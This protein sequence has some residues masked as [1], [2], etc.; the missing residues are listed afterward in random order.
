MTLPTRLVVIGASS[1]GID[2]LRSLV[3]GLP[4]DFPAPICVVVHTSPDGPRVLSD[5][6]QRAG[7]LP[8]EIAHSG[9]RLNLGRI[10][11]APADCHLLVEPGTLRVSRGPKE[12][13]FRPAIDPL[14][15]SAAQVY[16]PGAIGVILT[17]NLDDGVAGLWTIKRLGGVAIAQDPEEA[18]FPSMPRNAVE[19]VDVDHVV[20]LSQI[21]PLLVTLTKDARM[22]DDVE[23]PSSLDIEINIAREQN[24]IEAGVERL[25]TPSSWACPDC[26]GVLL[27]IDEGGRIRFRCH[28]GHAYSIESLVASVDDQIEADMWTAV[29]ALEEGAL[30]L[31]R[32]AEHIGA[33]HD[34]EH[35]RT[36]IGR[37]EEGHRQ[38]EAIRALL[39]ERNRLPLESER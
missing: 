9:A 25:G 7:H 23:P 36:L 12:N 29:R 8:A 27:K 13:R 3:G 18:A 39:K 20:Q 11:V 38:A 34:G 19:R 15:R 10:Y 26:H 21:P 33:R 35:A 17:G 32:M 14:F 37:S 22:R 2:A 16:G 31:G 30:L 28:T 6:L 24:A 1:G 5:I 4:P